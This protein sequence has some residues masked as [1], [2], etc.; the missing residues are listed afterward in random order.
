MKKIPRLWTGILNNINKVRY[1]EV[2]IFSKFGKECLVQFPFTPCL[3]E[4]VVSKNIWVQEV[5]RFSAPQI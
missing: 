5:H 1:L 4:S 3:M 2:A